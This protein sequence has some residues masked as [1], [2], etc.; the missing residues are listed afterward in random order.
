MGR[1]GVAPPLKVL[2]RPLSC[3]HAQ[4][5]AAL[6]LVHIIST[7]IRNALTLNSSNFS[8]FHNDHERMRLISLP[9]YVTTVH[10]HS[11]KE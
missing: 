8:F 10:G 6:G 4:L 1:G 3:V 11:K 2:V 9:Y 5:Y 7:F